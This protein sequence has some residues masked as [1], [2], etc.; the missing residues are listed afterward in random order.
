MKNFDRRIKRL[1]EKTTAI[2]IQQFLKRMRN[3]KDD[4]S[5]ISIGWELL[6]YQP[7]L[8]RKFD[9]PTAEAFLDALPAGYS[10]AVRRDLS[11]LVAKQTGDK[12]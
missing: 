5:K 1:E 9:F 3:A 6:K 8:V 7:S 4:A 2:V 11:E 12:E 10:I